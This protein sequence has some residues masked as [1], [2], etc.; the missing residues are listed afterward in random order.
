MLTVTEGRERTKDALSALC[1]QASLCLDKVITTASPMHIVE[2]RPVLTA[3]ENCSGWR[4]T[5]T[6]AVLLD[7]AGPTAAEITIWEE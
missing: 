6:I 4:R 1:N 5:R 3:A 7:V 2:A